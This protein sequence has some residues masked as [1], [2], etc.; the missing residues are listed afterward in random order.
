[1]SLYRS[2]RDR[3]GTAGVLLGVI[4]L[5]LALG[6]T[7]L[8]AK[9]ALTGKQKKEVEKIAKK[10]AGKPG[11]PGATGAPGPQGAPGPKGETGAKGD[12]GD[13][14]DTGNAGTPGTPGAAGK[15]VTLA[16]E[17]EGLNCGS[18]TGGGVKVE[19]E[20]NAASKKYVCNG[21]PWTAGGMLPPGQSET[22]TWAVNFT[23]NKTVSPAVVSSISFPIPVDSTG[24]EAFVFTEAEVEE[25]EFGASGCTGTWRLPESTKP[26]VL[27]VFTYNEFGS[28]HVT[29]NRI[30][31]KPI[32][33][34]PEGFGPTGVAIGVGTVSVEGG[35]Q[36]LLSFDGTW[37]VTAPEP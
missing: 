30:T 21:S 31:I 11:A 13:K 36:T 2:F 14:G 19:V 24:S 10:Y 15:S 22:G 5:I 32:S 1:M 12:K 27:C 17:P 9:G 18:G 3:F 4:A 26:G 33:G 20:G 7:A 8:A 37:A 28:E 35:E 23:T 25:E 34:F 29:G 16:S 6:G